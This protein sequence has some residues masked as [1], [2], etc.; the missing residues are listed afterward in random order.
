[1]RYVKASETKLQPIIEGTK[2]YLVPLFQRTY[3]WEK[4]EWGFLWDDLIELSEMDNPREHFIGSIVTTSAVS[5]PEGVAKF[6][7][8]DGQQRLT[9]IFIILALLRDKFTETNHNDLAEEIN[10]TLLINPYKK[11][12]ERYKLLPTHVDRTPFRNLID[13]QLIEGTDNQI[14]QAYRFF[15]R[16]IQQGQTDMIKLKDVISNHLSIVSIVLDQGDNPHLVF[17][18]LNA[19]GK[20]LT[21]SDLIRNFF[22]MR[23]H[24]DEQENVHRT[25]WRPMQEALGD[26]LTDYIRHYLMKSS[27]NIKQNEVYFSLKDRV[28]QGDAMEHL[29]DLLRFAKYYQNLLT[30]DYESN[31]KVR[32]CLK[33]LNRLDATTTYPFLLNCYDDYSRG[34]LPTS[35][36]TEV[37]N[38]IENFLIRRFVCNVPTNQLNKVFPP[39][40]GAITKQGALGFIGDLK[41]TL[42]SKGYPKDL[43]FKAR[44]QDANLYGSGDRARKTKLILE[45]IE[46]AFNHKEQVPFED[47]S[48]EHIMPQTLT[49]NWQGYLGDD[50]EIT[51]ELLLHT[52]G[53]LTLTAYNVEMS[54]DAFD[55]KKERFVNS[56]LELN[57]YFINV[58]TWKKEDMETRADVLAENALVV[59]PYFG[60]A[61]ESSD[62]TNNV[63]GTTPN[64]LWILGQRFKVNSW[65]DVFEHTLNTIADLEP[66]KFEQIINRFPRFVG[67][68]KKKFRAVRELRNGAFIEVNLSAKSIASF[69]FQALE[70]IE[71]TNEEWR[72]DIA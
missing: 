41:L 21:Q 4:K 65:R 53:N 64:A 38:V 24:V 25:Y 35:D 71:L 8:I 48:I 30:P 11:G 62:D 6:L 13:R 28:G 58:E 26:G 46:E 22:F 63:T 1:M 12:I 37:L 66:E 52:L 5:V 9:T 56:H 69:C 60:E 18:S 17:E 3:S 49:E 33:R 45:R 43:E 67:L 14:F 2:Q 68:D 31:Y 44:L 42:Q 50:W 40:Y 47:L 54:N 39:L 27:A 16:K 72:V 36:F 32:Q 29:A 23:I 10:N 55:R 19:K 70:L 34:I 59:W 7:L 57:K 51:H 61:K 15:E 20:A